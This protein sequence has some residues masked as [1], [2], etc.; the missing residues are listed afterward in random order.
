MKK[1]T[2]LLSNF[3]ALDVAEQANLLPRLVAAHHDEI[4]RRKKAL[5]RLQAP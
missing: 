2:Q 5:E 3:K 1:P 4:D